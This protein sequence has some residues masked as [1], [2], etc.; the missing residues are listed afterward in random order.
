MAARITGIS[1]MA[2][3]QVLDE[4]V[5][6]SSSARAVWSQSSRSAGLTQLSAYRPE[7]RLTSSCSRRTRS[8]NS[9]RRGAS[10]REQG[11]PRALGGG[12]RSRKGAPRPDV[13]SEDAVKRAVLAAPS[14][15]YSTGPSGVHLAKVVRAM[16]HRRGD[17]RPHRSGAARGGG[18]HLGGARRSRS[19]LPAVERTDAPAGNRRHRLAAGR[20]PDRHHVLGRGKRRV[21]S[22][23]I[24]RELLAFMG[25]P[26]ADK[27]KCTTA[28]SPRASRYWTPLRRLREGRYEK[29]D[30]SRLHVGIACDEVRFGPRNLSVTARTRRRARRSAPTPIP[31]APTGR[32]RS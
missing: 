30:C 25:S 7:R 27:V 1:S 15:S 24:A 3:R 5:T 9:W 31:R 12:D 26:A 22:P 20:D 11:R 32:L 10:W 21:G 2:T 29:T 19:R 8:T 16:G 17:C 6:A 23:D 4:L 18:R 13:G 14:I 28:W